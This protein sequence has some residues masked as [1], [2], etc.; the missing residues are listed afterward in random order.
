MQVME[1]GE[2]V[3][4]SDIQTG[5]TVLSIC[6]VNDRLAVSSAADDISLY[7]LDSS[8]KPVYWKNKY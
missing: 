3:L 8:L 7:E 6:F 1:S 4:V 5:S 2:L